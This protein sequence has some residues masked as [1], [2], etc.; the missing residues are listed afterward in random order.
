[1]NS[2][3]NTPHRWKNLK[4]GDPA[5]RKPKCGTWLEKTL[6]DETSKPTLKKSRRRVQNYPCGN[7][8][9]C[10]PRTHY[11]GEVVKPECRP[12]DEET[13]GAFS[14]HDRAKD[15]QDAF[16]FRNSRW[17]WVGRFTVCTTIS[18]KPAAYVWSR[19]SDGAYFINELRSKSD[20]RL[21][22]EEQKIQVMDVSSPRMAWWN[23]S[24][25]KTYL[26]QMS[27]NS[28][29]LGQMGHFHTFLRGNWLAGDGLCSLVSW[30]LESCVLGAI[31]AFL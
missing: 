3:A 11:F 24:I 23:S 21:P 6:A 16:D 26:H 27:S 8:D 28:T 2:L 22:F 13:F 29:S 20:P 18:K 10:L 15:E 1:M 14:R 4:S 5:A 12:L 7:Q 17:L 25:G 9:N 30:I 19:L 31:L